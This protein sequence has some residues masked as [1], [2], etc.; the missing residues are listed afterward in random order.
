MGKRIGGSHA[1]EGAG[2]VMPPVGIPVAWHEFLK[3]R[4]VTTGVVIW[5][6]LV[7]ALEQVHGKDPGA[8]PPMGPPARRARA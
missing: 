8:P 6:Q 5:R 4:R 7:A 3:A 1:L 2:Q